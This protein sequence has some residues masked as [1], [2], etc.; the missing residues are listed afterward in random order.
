MANKRVRISE[1]EFDPKIHVKEY[2][3]TCRECGKVWQSLVE[4]EKKIEKEISRA[5]LQQA[6][7]ACCNPATATQSQRTAA[8]HENALQQLRRCPNCGSQN[9]SEEIIIYEKEK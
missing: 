8:A 9:Y 6:G 5:S 2:K 4:R 7:F 1:E 3:R